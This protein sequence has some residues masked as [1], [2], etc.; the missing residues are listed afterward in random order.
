MAVVAASAASKAEPEP[1]PAVRRRHLP[2]PVPAC[3]ALPF[4]DSRHFRDRRPVPAPSPEKPGATPV[5]R[6]LDHPSSRRARPSPR[7]GG[8]A[9]RARGA[10]PLVLGAARRRTGPSPPATG[11]LTETGGALL[12]ASVRRG[13]TRPP[14]PPGGIPLEGGMGPCHPDLGG[15]DPRPP[16]LLFSMMVKDAPVPQPINDPF[17]VSMAATCFCR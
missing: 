16:R 4:P 6:P 17:I 13:A 8:A 10:I 7:V 5:G 11:R 9:G 15:S 1:E 12:A 2:S 14:R 3:A